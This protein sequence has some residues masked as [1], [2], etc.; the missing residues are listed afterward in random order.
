[1]S[2]TIGIIRTIPE[3]RALHQQCMEECWR[4]RMS[5]VDTL[6]ATPPGHYSVTLP[7]EELSEIDYWN[8]SMVR[9]GRAVNGLDPC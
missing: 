5:Y 8:G 3:T 2:G 7:G 6:P 1:V 9:Q 4:D